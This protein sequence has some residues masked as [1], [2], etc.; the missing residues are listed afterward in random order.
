MYAVRLH[1][2][3]PAENLRYEVV[4]DPR[5]GPGEVRIR[6]EAAGVHVIDTRLRE[7]I[8]SGPLPAP[9]LPTVPG[10]EVAGAV[11]EVGVGVDPAWR[12]QRVV[13]HLGPD[14]HGY[15]ERAVRSVAHIH[16]VADEL[17][18]ATAVAMIGTGRTTMGVLEVAALTARDVVLITAAAGGIGGLL[19]QAARHAGATVVG[20]A[21]GAAK[22]EAVRRLGAHVAVDY[23]LPDWPDAVRD[24]LEGRPVTVTLDG[25][26][27][28][29]GRAALDLTGRGGRV[30]MFGWSAGEPTAVTPADVAERGLRV[31]SELPGRIMRRPGGIAALED[32]ALAAATAGT[33]VPSIQAFPLARA[34]AAHSALERRETIGKVV[35]VP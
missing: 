7:G 2:F 34:A 13:A 20:V 30:L 16:P 21:G 31:E 11:D 18:A 14:G 5:P 6:V 12:G 4:E 25:V 9:T 32:A 8:P 29:S 35:L 3:G 23:T 10:R 19:V 27:G 33:L 22:V 28:R 15:A 17:T 24:A 26:G 1:E